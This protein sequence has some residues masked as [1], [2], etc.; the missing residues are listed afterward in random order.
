MDFSGSA[1]LKADDDDRIGKV[2]LGVTPQE[3]ETQLAESDGTPAAI[4]RLANANVGKEFKV[5]C[6]VHEQSEKGGRKST[7]L[8]ATW[9]EPI[10]YAATTRFFQEETDKL[11]S[12][13][14]TQGRLHGHLMTL[15]A[16]FDAP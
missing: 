15:A 8:I 14:L 9:V 1:T 7:N 16:A 11:M 10:D 5:I 4:K 6:K 2:I 3:W 13:P 12:E